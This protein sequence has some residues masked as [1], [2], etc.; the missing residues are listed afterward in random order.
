MPTSIVLVNTDGIAEAER[1]GRALVE[2]RLA[3][4]V[5][6][7]GGISSFFRWQGAVRSRDEA[8]LIVK[9]RADLVDAVVARVLD[10][11]GYECPSILVLP[12]AGGNT[13]YLAWVER[14]TR[15]D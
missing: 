8:Q 5:N 10:L 7:A 1:I 12:V 9:T 14:E 11:H 13:E 4:A 3:A 15:D 2:S 6:V